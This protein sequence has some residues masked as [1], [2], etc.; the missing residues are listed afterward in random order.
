MGRFER[1]EESAKEAIAPRLLRRLLLGWLFAV[2]LETLLMPPGLRDLS[3]LTGLS[4]MSLPR[5]LLVTAGTVLGLE[6]LSRLISFDTGKVERWLLLLLF[7]LDAGLSLI[8]SFTWPFLAACALILF[9]LIVYA[10]WGWRS[11]PQKPEENAKGQPLWLCL[12]VLLSLMFLALVSVWTVCRVKSFYTPTYDFG[13]FSQMF[14][15]MKKTGLPLTT[16]ERDGLLSH[17]KVHFSP[18]YYL[19]LPFYFLV[20]KPETLQVLQAVVLA[21]AVI[22]LWLLGKHRGLPAP[23]RFL[24]CALLLL[25]PSFSGGTSYDI[26]ENCFLTPLLLWLLYGIDRKSLPISLAAA[27]LTLGV[28]EDAAVYA[29]VIALYLIVTGLLHRDGD[30]RWNLSVG[31][32]IFAL[33]LLWFFL[34]TSW[35][36]RSGDGV[37]TYR[38]EN[39]MYDGSGSLVTVI[40]AVLLQPLKAVYE[41]VDPE[42]LEFLALSLLPLLGLPLWT[43]RFERLILLISFLLV[44]LMS[45]YPY[46]HDIFFQYTYGSTACL[47]YLSLVNLADWKRSWRDLAVLAAA[48]AVCL[49]CFCTVV[50]PKAI[51]HPKR[52]LK[53]SAKY[54]QIEEEL[55]SIPEDAAAASTTFHTTAL[56]GREIL[57][58]VKYASFEHLLE[59]EYIVLSPTETTSYTKYAS[60]G[61]EDGLERLLEQLEQNGYQKISAEDSILLIYQREP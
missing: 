8:S 46:Q 16:L 60:D 7:C 43:R 52:C 51:P 61:A 57:Y 39:F 56:S 25:Y 13:L 53:N 3:K 2:V 32:G 36:A 48:A 40:K 26:H 18:I 24:F 19:L 38:Y 28:K 15:Y 42:K 44:N 10:L 31:I 22:P 23:V 27:I 30:R 29:A 17:F 4:W 20:P 47:F 59:A 37:M 45:D 14:Y 41:C 50:V 6:V 21:S 9:G 33:S 35:L 12:T 54:A 34:V 5:V 1:V 55:S 58:D 11:D 49:F